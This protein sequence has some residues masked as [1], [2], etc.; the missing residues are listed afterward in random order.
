M[1]DPEFTYFGRVN[2]R[3]EIELP[4]KKIRRE[5][6]LLSGT[7]I[8]VRFRRKRKR[9]SVQEN[10]YYWGCIVQSLVEA[11]REWDAEMG[12]TAEMVHEYLKQRFL[13]LVREWSQTITP[14]G[15]VIDEPLTT[16]KLTTVEAETY[17]E[18]C[19]KWAAEMDVLIPL[20]N[21]QISIFL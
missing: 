14:H 12:W 1:R 20:P 17:Y 11:F 19:R 18:M 2:E 5:L 8:E 9:R 15:E 4:G 3:G 21:E 10:N 7:L 16:T 6:R 13:P